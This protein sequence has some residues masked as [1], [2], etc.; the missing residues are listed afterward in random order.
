MEVGGPGKRAPRLR[1]VEREL[2][3]GKGLDREP[4]A[5]CRPVPHTS[6]WFGSAH[7]PAAGTESE[8][9]G[10]S[11]GG[12]ERRGRSDYVQLFQKGG[13]GRRPGGMRL[14]GAWGQAGAGRPQLW[15]WA[16]ELV[17]LRS[18]WRDWVSS[19][20]W[21]LQRHPGPGP[22]LGKVLGVLSRCPLWPIHCPTNR[23]LVQTSRSATTLLPSFSYQ[24]KPSVFYLRQFFFCLSKL[25][26]TY[27][28]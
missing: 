27:L 26:K 9:A 8:R 17:T 12:A 20:G 15:W 18:R 25:T 2:W 6:V 5:T 10:G 13:K 11:V 19:L 28:F 7:W 4:A 16:L 22:G 3:S 1:P 24:N 23:E 14:R 21:G